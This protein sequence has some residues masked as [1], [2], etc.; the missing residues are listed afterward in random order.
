MT[1]LKIDVHNIRQ[2]FSTVGE[3]LRE[4][5]GVFAFPSPVRLK[6]MSM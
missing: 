3:M 5:D 1:T 6:S 4:S 2:A